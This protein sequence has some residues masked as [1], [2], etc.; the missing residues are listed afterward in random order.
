MYC[1]VCREDRR[2]EATRRYQQN[3]RKGL[4]RKLGDIDTCE[5]C[6]NTYVIGA[7]A[8]RICPDCKDDHYKEHDRQ[9]GLDYYYRNKS[10][11]NEKRN[12]KRRIGTRKCA[13][14]GSEFSTSTRRLTCSDECQ[15]LRTNKRWNDR[16]ARKKSG[17]HNPILE[18]SKDEKRN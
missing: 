11:I 13:W 15:R 18:D 7:G 1:T 3:K 10:T 14:C 16:H 4:T 12:E 5:K 9:S 6:G 17:Y 2:R 8:Q